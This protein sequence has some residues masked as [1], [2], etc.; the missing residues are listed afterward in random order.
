M[1]VL[2]S[3]CYEA[4]AISDCRQHVIGRVRP[5]D[6]ASKRIVYTPLSWKPKNLGII[7]SIKDMHG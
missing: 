5:I 1:T 7:R 3:V 6:G 4:A 2:I